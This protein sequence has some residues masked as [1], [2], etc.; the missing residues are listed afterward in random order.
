MKQIILFFLLATTL[1]SNSQVFTYSANSAT[2]TNVPGGTMNWNVTFSNHSASPISIQFE[3]YQKY[4]PPYWYSCF[5]YINCNPPTLDTITINLAASSSSILSVLFKTDSVNPGTA[6]SSIR[7]YQSGFANSADTVHLNA[8]T[9]A[10]AI[11]INEPKLFNSFS[12]YPN[13]LIDEIIISQALN[14]SYSICVMDINGKII[15]QVSNLDNKKYSLSLESYPSGT[16]FIKLVYQSGK[17][18]TKK[19][20]KN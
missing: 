15:Q 2:M 13:P 3:R 7:I 10:A 12:S 11:H 17:T 19:I 5:C 18:E 6:T 8:S 14:E 20:I 16:Y 4:N 1:K 9:A